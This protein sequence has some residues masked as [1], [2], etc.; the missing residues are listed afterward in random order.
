MA[1]GIGD[2]VALAPVDLLACIIT[3]RTATFRRLDRLAIDHPGRRA[4]FPAVAFAGMRAVGKITRQPAPSA[5]RSTEFGRR[6]LW[7]RDQG[8]QTQG[9]GFEPP[10]PRFITKVACTK[11]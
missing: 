8:S 3:P 4:R 7:A 9:S 1:A 5:T 2:N 11:G 10:V 6:A